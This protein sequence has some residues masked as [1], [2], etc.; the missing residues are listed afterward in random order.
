MKRED[1]AGKI[2]ERII[3]ADKELA[4]EAFESL[5]RSVGNFYRNE[6]GLEGDYADLSYGSTLRQYSE[7]K[8]KKNILDIRLDQQNKKIVIRKITNPK[9][10]HQERKEK[11][12]DEIVAKK[13][14]L[15]CKDGEFKI[16]E[17]DEYLSQSFAEL[18]KEND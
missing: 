18:I 17:V 16:E 2:R 13:G 6:I 10:E 9:H 3:D 15:S 8:F 5:R 14:E 7:L 4:I 1:L 11:V 12:L